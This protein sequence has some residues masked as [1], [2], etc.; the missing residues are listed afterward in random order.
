[1]RQICNLAYAWLRAD[2]VAAL[3]MASGKDRA[4]ALA[5]LDADINA[6]VGGWESADHNLRAAI[7]TAE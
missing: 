2:L 5:D 6:P 4:R 3:P 1:M 7:F